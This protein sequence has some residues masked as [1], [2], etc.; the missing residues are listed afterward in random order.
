MDD[1]DPFQVALAFFHAATDPARIPWELA[2]D[3]ARLRAGAAAIGRFVAGNG[4]LDVVEYPAP[5]WAQFRVV[6]DVPA[7][8]Y[9]WDGRSDL[10]SP[11][12]ITLAWLDD[13]EGWRIF[14][15]GSRV[16]P[17]DLPDDPRNPGPRFP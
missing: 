16:D 15:I 1:T 2:V 9:R 12:A 11:G 13:V 10:A 3:E 6:T 5:G 8:G 14:H 7:D 17:D 4:L